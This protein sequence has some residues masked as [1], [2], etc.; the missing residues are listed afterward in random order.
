[1]TFDG[2]LAVV[3]VRPDDSHRLRLFDLK[4]LER[5]AVTSPGFWICRVME[6][7]LLPEVNI[8]GSR[9][10]CQQMLWTL[11]DELPTQVRKY[12]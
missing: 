6:P 11:R 12:Q 1:L 5:T 10:A 3:E 8:P 7:R 9:R 2:I 4:E